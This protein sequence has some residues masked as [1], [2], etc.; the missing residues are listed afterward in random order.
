[1]YVGLKIETVKLKL[2]IKTGLHS[3]ASALSNGNIHASEQDPTIEIPLSFSTLIFP[4]RSHI[5]CKNMLFYRNENWGL[6]MLWMYIIWGNALRTLS[7]H[8]YPTVYTILNCDPNENER[9][10]V[11]LL[12]HNELLFVLQEFFPVSIIMQV[13]NMSR[14]GKQNKKAPRALEN[15]MKTILSFEHFVSILTYSDMF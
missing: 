3:L 11:E 13:V 5:L 7:A 8:T 2:G 9:D 14:T 4:H 1:M 10:N 6:F 15:C 12:Q